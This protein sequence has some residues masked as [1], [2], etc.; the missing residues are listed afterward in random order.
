MR[1][2]T[3]IVADGMHVRL[4]WVLCLVGKAG[5]ARGNLVGSTLIMGG[6]WAPSW[7][8]GGQRVKEGPQLDVLHHD[9]SSID[10]VS[11]NSI[12]IVD[13]MIDSFIIAESAID[14]SLI[15]V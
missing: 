12:Q 11:V 15:V 8:Q 2:T 13:M 6:R 5:G 4:K 14:P 1:L 3:F 9:F 10:D 7:L